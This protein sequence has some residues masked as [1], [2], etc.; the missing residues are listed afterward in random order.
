[1]AQ[2]VVERILQLQASDDHETDSNEYEQESLSKESC[3]NSEIDVVHK[4]A[5][6][7]EEGQGS[8]SRPLELGSQHIDDSSEDDSTQSEIDN[9]EESYLIDLIFYIGKIKDTAIRTLTIS[10]LNQSSDFFPLVHLK[11]IDSDQT[12]PFDI[13]TFSNGD[14]IINFLCANNLE[15]DSTIEHCNEASKQG[16]IKSSNYKMNITRNRS[17]GENHSMT[18]LDPKKSKNKERIQWQKPL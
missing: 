3:H 4:Y 5:P 6:L 15:I 11:L 9:S 12:K 1:M 7:L 14:A 17:N 2:R 10:D 8:G 16:S 18:L 13:P